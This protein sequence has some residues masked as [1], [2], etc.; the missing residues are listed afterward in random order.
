MDAPLPVEE[1]P[2]GQEKPAEPAASAA[3]DSRGWTV[4]MDKAPKALGSTGGQPGAAAPEAAPAA[5]AP[6]TAE[7]D[8]GD[9]RTV[10]AGGMVPP[11]AGAGQGQMPETMYFKSGAT[12]PEHTG[13]GGRPPTQE[14]KASV[15]KAA[16]EELLSGA[17]G[18]QAR[19]QAPAAPAVV[20][21]QAVSPGRSAPVAVQGSDSGKTMVYVG[22]GL[23]VLALIIVLVLL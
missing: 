7:P 19:A 16:A 1:P 18:S 3:S 15:P 14:I 12:Q 17:S 8:V 20:Q 2:P 6:A 9:G 22:V 4:F 10:M 11:G 5:A 13:V 23:G 21:T